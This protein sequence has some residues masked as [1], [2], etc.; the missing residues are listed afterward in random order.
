[1]ITITKVGRAALVPSIFIMMFLSGLPAL[2]AQQEVKPAPLFDDLGDH[3]HRISTDEPLA[4]EYFDQGLT[5]AYAFNHPEAIRSFEAAAEVD[6]Q[7][8]M[9]WWGVALAHGPNI[10]KPM[11]VE[12]GRLAYAALEKAQALAEHAS[13]REQAYIAALAKRYEADPPEDRAHLDRAYAEAMAEVARAYPDDLDAQTL[14]AEAAMDTMPWDY[15]EE[16]REQLKPGARQVQSA[17]EEVLKR[18]PDHPGAN[19]FYIH[20]VEA[21]PRPWT[22]E[23][24]A[25]RLRTLVPG[26]GHLVHMPAHIYVR[27]GRYHDAVE[28][29][30]DA[31]AAD[32]SYITQ[33]RVQGFYPLA[34]YPH[35]MHFTWYAA[36]L[37]GEGETAIKAARE[38]TEGL[39]AH[40]GLHEPEEL[41]E[42]P[43][44][45]PIITFTLVRFGQWEQLLEEPT[46]PA[47]EVYPAAMDHYGR[48][49]AHLRTGDLEA[50]KQQAGMLAAII[51]TDE[52][53]AAEE[54]LFAH[55]QMRIAHQIVQG[56]LA[57]AQQ[58][59]DQAVDHLRQAVALEDELPYMEPPYWYYPVRQ[60]L[61]R[62][63]LEAGQPVEAEQAFRQDLV[64][65][66]RNGWSLR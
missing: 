7:C 60:T 55:T 61:G 9:A 21:G 54:G 43:R 25:D 11:S 33:C 30:H 22:A 47:A 31:V 29:N 50:A 38:V 44:F 59:H 56:E 34:Y 51:E 40:A 46:P 65:H 18:N 32:E 57:A 4:Q 1:M 37:S 63:L 49:L 14:Y 20:L 45:D 64:K 23:A 10:N 27:I 12:E 16:G 35:N 66:P 39:H 41:P 3:H 58:Q 13:A 19:H 24:M 52:A 36:I 48:A 15:W 26:A 17:L 53:K 42:G 5:L 28:V 2:A 8:A 62:V 6:P